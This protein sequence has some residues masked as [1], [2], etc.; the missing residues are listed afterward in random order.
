MASLP[1][2]LPPHLTP[3]VA[4]LE[5]GLSRPGLPPEA[6]VLPLPRPLVGRRRL[7]PLLMLLARRHRRA[8][9]GGETPPPAPTPPPDASSGGVRRLGRALASGALSLTPSGRGWRGGEWR[10]VGT[11]PAPPPPLRGRRPPRRSP[12]PPALET[13]GPEG[14]DGFLTLGLVAAGLALAGAH[15]ATPNGALNPNQELDQSLE[16]LDRSFRGKRWRLRLNLAPRLG[17]LEPAELLGL[18]APRLGLAEDGP[19]AT[20]LGQALALG[21]RPLPLRPE[22][23]FGGRGDPPPSPAQPL[24][25]QLANLLLEPLDR[26]GLALEGRDRRSRRRQN[27]PYTRLLHLMA[28]L[29]KRGWSTLPPP[30]RGSRHNYGDLVGEGGWQLRR[31]LRATPSVLA[32]DD[33]YL[34]CRYLRHGSEVLVG[35]AGSLGEA[36]RLRAELRGVLEGVGLGG[37][38]L[39][40]PSLRPFHRPFTFAGWEVHAPRRSHLPDRSLGVGGDPLHAPR[41]VYP[42]LGLGAPLGDLYRWLGERGFFRW[43][44]PPSG[45]RPH[46]RP[47][48]QRGLLG[49]SPRRLLTLFGELEGVLAHYYAS[50]DNHRA[51]GRLRDRLRKSATLTLAAKHRLRPGGVGERFGGRL[52]G[53]GRELPPAPRTPRGLSFRRLRGATLTPASP[54]PSGRVRGA[55]PK[56]RC[57]PRP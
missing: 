34:R 31:R 23:P 7:R 19:L 47:T 43:Y 56:A 1:A 45:G 49:G 4:E 2:S 10:S 28:T 37:G 30:A 29:R 21:V 41:R 17:E 5:V 38:P 33:A 54:L 39:A 18:L 57:A 14:L 36:R 51:L 13:L 50:A 20:A 24:G 32:D 12:P 46:W 8:L 42:R 35:V 6:L 48:A 3:T 26:W 25:T 52:G 44:S 53:G 16:R 11:P 40:T 22:A 9:G 55:G 27:P 15:P